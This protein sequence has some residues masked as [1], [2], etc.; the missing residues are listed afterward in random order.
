VSVT[1]FMPFIGGWLSVRPETAGKTRMLAGLA[2]AATNPG[3]TVQNAGVEADARV[4]PD[5]FGAYPRGPFRQVILSV[6]V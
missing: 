1:T 6:V 2:A 5:R 3:D 4:R